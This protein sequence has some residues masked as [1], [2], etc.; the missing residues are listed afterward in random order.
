MITYIQY[1]FIFLIL[2]YLV[3]KGFEEFAY[4][5]IIGITYIIA[6][7]IRLYFKIKRWIS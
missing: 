7:I 3:K 2:Y 1:I 5:F 6:A 4:D